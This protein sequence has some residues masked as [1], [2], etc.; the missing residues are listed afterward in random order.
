MKTISQ[1]QPLVPSYRDKAGGG[2]IPVGVLSCS[3]CN[4][5]E[6]SRAAA[7]RLGYPTSTDWLLRNW[8]CGCPEYQPR[9]YA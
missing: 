4:E 7:A 8:S 5:R 1:M 6:D 3:I 2:G 9:K